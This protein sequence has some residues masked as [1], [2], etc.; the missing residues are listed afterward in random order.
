MLPNVLPPGGKRHTLSRHPATTDPDFVQIAV[1]R[2]DGT[3]AKLVLPAMPLSDSISG[4]QTWRDLSPLSTIGQDAEDM[5]HVL[6]DT[7]LPAYLCYPNRSC[8]FEYLEDEKILYVHL[9]QNTT[10][11]CS[12]S[13][14]SK[15][16][17]QAFSAYPMEDVVVDIRF[18]SGGDLTLTSK[19]AQ[20]HF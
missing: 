16:V 4:H 17:E 8:S 11:D 14:F 9:N 7:G 12:I 10:L 5:I 19:L 3:I 1:E 6:A 20:R 13:K 2:L 15:E 18:N